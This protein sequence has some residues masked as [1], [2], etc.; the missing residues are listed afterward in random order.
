MSAQ[1]AA[2]TRRLVSLCE[3]PVSGEGG[4]RWSADDGGG[5]G[6]GG[7]GGAGALLDVL[8]LDW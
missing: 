4:T 1:E 8:E 6:G 5:G 3:V 7:G 2:R